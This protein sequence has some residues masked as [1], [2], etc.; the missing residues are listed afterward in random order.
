MPVQ[1]RILVQL[2]SMQCFSFVE[3]EG[4]FFIFAR[5]CLIC[6]F[7]KEQA[8]SFLRLLNMDCF[9]SHA[10]EYGIFHPFLLL[11]LSLCQHESFMSLVVSCDASP[12]L[13]AQSHHCSWQFSLENIF[14]SP[15]KNLFSQRYQGSFKYI[16]VFAA[17][18]QQ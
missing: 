3:K 1:L 8:S 9:L 4:P 5:V 12:T 16:L 6:C 17:S 11:M 13:P 2:N 18:L 14:L 10:K 15:D 7:N